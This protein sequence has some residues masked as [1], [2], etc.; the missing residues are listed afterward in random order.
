MTLNYI[1]FDIWWDTDMTILP[2]LCKK[3][4]VNVF[5]VEPCGNDKGKYPHKEDYGF[6]KFV[7]YKPKY[8]NWDIRKAWGSLKLFR[9]IYK[10]CKKKDAVN[11]FIF[12]GEAYWVVLLYFFLSK[13]N[14]IIAAHNYKAHI[15]NRKN[16]FTYCY[17]RYCSRFSRFLFFSSLQRAEFLKDHPT[18]EAF[19]ITMPLKDF[20]APARK[21]EDNKITFLFFGNMRVYK[22][23]DLYI[24]AANAVSA[25]Q[26]RFLMVGSGKK[27]SYASLI[28]RPDDFLLDTR[29]VANEEIPDI[30]CNADFL[31]LP[32]E[33]ATQSG[34]SLIA[35]NYGI[36]IIASRLPAFERLVTDGENGYLFP[37]GDAD[38]L[39]NVFKTV[40][41][42]GRPNIERMKEN[43]RKFKAEYVRH[44]DVLEVF[45]K[46]L[47]EESGRESLH[48]SAE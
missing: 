23:P 16:I 18:K 11:L 3:Y 29:H 8:H 38:A 4:K 17:Q 31:V 21:R 39:A 12:G 25:G 2:E 1:T 42:K 44:N 6:N 27:E 14:S 46:M 20:G 37:S 9:Q 41:E 24:K 35:V 47:K 43:M 5:E 33:D 28:E 32:Y 19:N 22:R 45:G 26:A 34:P 10:E 15:D 30:F 7:I 13:R 40:I 48:P 36:P